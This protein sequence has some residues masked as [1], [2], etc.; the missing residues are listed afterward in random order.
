MIAKRLGQRSY[1]ACK[2]ALCIKE[3]T[4]KPSDLSLV[5]RTL[6]VKVDNQLLQITLGPAC[7]HAHTRT[8]VQRDR[9]MDG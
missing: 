1:Q 7:R 4:T 6:I 2:M 8:C 3:L 5:L 9:Q